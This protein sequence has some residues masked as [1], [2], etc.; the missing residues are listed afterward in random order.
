MVE[1]RVFREKLLQVPNRIHNMSL[2]IRMIR[3]VGWKVYWEASD[4]IAFTYNK[5]NALVATEKSSFS[6]YE[7]DA[8]TTKTYTYTELDLYGNWLTR[9]VAAVEEKSVTE[10]GEETATTTQKNLPVVIE[11]REI[12]YW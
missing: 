11:K 6:D 8:V 7:V 2:N 3:K 5:V 9:E 10:M 4:Y 1:F 12:Q